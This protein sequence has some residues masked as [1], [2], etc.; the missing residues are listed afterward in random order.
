MI[1]RTRAS[2][3]PIRMSLLIDAAGELAGAVILAVAGAQLA[4]AFSLDRAYIWLASGIFLAATVGI[5]GLVAVR[6]ESRE[7]VLGLAGSNIAAGL[8]GWIALILMWSAIDPGGRWVLAA[9]AD[10]FIL[11]GILELLALRRR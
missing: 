4:D 2:L 11:V 3:S 1:G 5:A 8:A 10:S 6:V 9:A 7:L